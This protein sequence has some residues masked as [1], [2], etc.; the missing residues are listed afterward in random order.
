MEESDSNTRGSL[1]ISSL[2]IEESG[3]STYIGSLGVSSDTE[4]EN[5]FNRVGRDVSILNGHFFKIVKEDD[6]KPNKITALCLKCKPKDVK[7]KGYRNSTSNFVSHLKRRHQ[8][9]GSFEE[10]QNYK[11]K[12]NEFKTPSTKC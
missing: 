2:D 8:E 6:S 11:K 5:D 3:P 1:G 10:Y 4:D 9:D 7:I 12:E